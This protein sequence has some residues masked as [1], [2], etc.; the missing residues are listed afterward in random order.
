MGAC[1]RRKFLAMQVVD[2]DTRSTR[3]Y[4][5][6]CASF[7]QGSVIKT[8]IPKQALFAS[9]AFLGNLIIETLKAALID[10]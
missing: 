4:Q 3:R 9:K 7:C 10:L 5:L 8:D 6:R 1:L 2:A